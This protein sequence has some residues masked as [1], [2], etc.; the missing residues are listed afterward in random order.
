VTGVTGVM[1]KEEMTGDGV[2]VGLK[3]QVMIHVED[4]V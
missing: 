2:N 1:Y 4:I 3:A